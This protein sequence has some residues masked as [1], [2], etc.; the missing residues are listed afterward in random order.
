MSEPQ[1]TSQLPQ[2]IQ[3]HIRRYLDSN[4]ADGHVIDM[5]A[6]GGRK[7]TPTLLLTTKGRKTGKKSLLPLIYGE[8][9][10]RYVIIASKGGAPNHPSWYF[11][12]DADPH[13][14][15]QVGSKRMHAV[16]QTAHGDQRSQLWKKMVSVY[17]PYVDYQT[18][19]KRE[20]PVVVLTP[21]KGAG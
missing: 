15:I 20:I 14:D 2:W 5:T 12:L 9:N 21:Q 1:A 10:G 6:V 3:D 7:D 4:G 13:V 17:P 11:N 18:K 8:D 19:T 16:A